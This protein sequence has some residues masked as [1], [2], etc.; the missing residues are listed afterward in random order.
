M[1]D[2]VA[3]RNLSHKIHFLGNVADR[4]VLKSYYTA[5]DL[6]LFPSLYD[7]APL[8]VR[9]A[10]GLHTPSLL[11]RGATCADEIVDNYNGFLSD[12]SVDF[13]ADRLQELMMN[14]KLVGDV[15]LRASSTIVRSWE[16]IADEVYDRYQRLIHKSRYNSPRCFTGGVM[17]ERV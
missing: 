12:H 15:G 2:R 10:A 6:F 1:V 17:Y 8:V 7:N 11:L 13:F 9:E 5:A 14:P 16:D 4:N 3:E